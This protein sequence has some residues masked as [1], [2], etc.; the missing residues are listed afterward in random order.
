MHGTISHSCDQLDDGVFFSTEISRHLV[1]YSFY[2]QS[3][4][5]VTTEHLECLIA[6][7]AGQDAGIVIV[8]ATAFDPDA[9]ERI[10]GHDREVLAERLRE[11]FT[12]GKRSFSLWIYIEPHRR[13]ADGVRWWTIRKQVRPGGEAAAILARWRA[14]AA[15]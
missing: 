10:E 9:Y 1:T 15:S 12:P 8:S 11:F 6:K 14:A 2:Q 3:A 4:G 7:I 13:D 5:G